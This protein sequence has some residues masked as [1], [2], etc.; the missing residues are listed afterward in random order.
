MAYTEVDQDH[1][2]VPFGFKVSKEY[3]TYEDMEN[4]DRLNEEL[5]L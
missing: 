2:W 4:P 5:K 3:A 1:P